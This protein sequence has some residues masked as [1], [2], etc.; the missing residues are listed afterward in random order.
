M[1]EAR[2]AQLWLYLLMLVL[3][4]LPFALLFLRSR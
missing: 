4:F 1:E 2:R 3:V